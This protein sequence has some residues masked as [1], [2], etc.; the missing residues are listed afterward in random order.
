MSKKL[1]SCL[2]FATLSWGATIG[3]ET[4]DTDNGVLVSNTIASVVV[5]SPAGGNPGGHM[6]TR[7]DL[8]QP[9]FDIGGLTTDSRFTGDYGADGITGMTVDLNFMTSNF[10]GAWFRV[11]ID[12]ATNGWLAPLTAV[13]PTDT[14]TTYTLAFDPTW[15]DLEARA[16][17]W[18][19]DFD[20]DPLAGASPSFATVM[21]SVGRAEIRLGTKDESS[22]AGIDNLGLTGEVP[23]PSTMFLMSAGLGLIG[24]ARLR[25]HS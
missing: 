4:F 20:L 10:T 6:L 8:G 7:R 18:I 12:A 1:G 25:R 11:R 9:F 21:A 16:A 23:E 24:L 15:T 22:L 3:T 2:L 5:H 13:F 17:G 19:T 14:W